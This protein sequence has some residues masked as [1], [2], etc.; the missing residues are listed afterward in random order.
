VSG[1]TIKGM[2]SN[3]IR[4]LDVKGVFVEIGLIPNSDLAKGIVPFNR[5]GEI[6]VSLQL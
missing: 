1:I 4:E 6:E 2:K 5:L 3:E